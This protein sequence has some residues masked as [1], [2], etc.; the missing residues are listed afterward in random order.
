MITPEKFQ[1]LM[2]KPQ[3]RPIDCEYIKSVAHLLRVGFVAVGQAWW[4]CS[5]Q[6]IRF[7]VLWSPWKKFCTL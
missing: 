2:E 4:P 7:N 5:E 1:H 3:L 6:E